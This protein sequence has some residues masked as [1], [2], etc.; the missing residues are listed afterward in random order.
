MRHALWIAAACFVAAVALS[1]SRAA[2][3]SR[4]P[5]PAAAQAAPT[6]RRGKPADAWLPTR[7]RFRST[8]SAAITRK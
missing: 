7:R 5:A 1:V 8:A 6:L 4:R 3:P 2:S